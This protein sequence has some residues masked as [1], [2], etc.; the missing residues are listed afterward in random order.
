MRV[1]AKRT[2][3]LSLL[4][5]LCVVTAGSATEFSAAVETLDIRESTESVEFTITTTEPVRYTYFELDGP[6]L[7]VDFHDA[8]NLLGSLNQPVGAAGVESVRAAAFSNDTRDVT[9]IV[10]D[11]VEQTPYEVVDDGAGQVR[12]LFGRVEETV[13]ETVAEDAG[14]ETVEDVGPDTGIDQNQPDRAGES[15]SFATAG[16]ISALVETTFDRIVE[17]ATT[18]VEAAPTIGEAAPTIGEELPTVEESFE[19]ETEIEGVADLSSTIVPPQV[20]EPRAEVVA[21]IASTAPTQLPPAALAEPAVSAAGFAQIETSV[22]SVLAETLTVQVQAPLA[23]APAAA[24]PVF[25]RQ[26]GEPSE[27]QYTGEIVSFNLVGSELT[28]FFR[29]IAELSG[30]NIILDEGVTGSLTLVLTEVPWDQALD[31]VLRTNNLGYELEG[32]ILRIAPQAVFQAEADALQA[33]RDA[34][35]LNVPMETR[36]YILS[37]TTAGAVLPLIT[38]LISDAAADPIVDSRRNA[39]IITDIPGRFEAIESLI[40]FLDTPS[41]QVEIEARLLSATKSFSRELG[42]LL[43]LQARNALNPAGNSVTFNSIL[44]GAASGTLQFILGNGG[45]VILDSIITTAEAN[46]TAKLLSRPRIVTQNNVAATVSQG[47]QIPVQTNVNNTISVDFV[48]F[49][50]S[51]EV[52]PQITEAGTI[53]LVATI[54]NSSPDFS[55]PVGGIPAVSTQTAQTTVLIPDGGTAV[56]GGILIDSDS[57]STSQIPGLGSIPVIGS[58]FR[59][60]RTVRNTSELLFFITARIKATDPLEFLSGAVEDESELFGALEDSTLQ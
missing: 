1:L 60:T 47:T 32:N 27:P 42:T 45:D 57:V 29:V 59:N 53:L 30:L 8:E 40:D 17:A 43:G 58:L 14:S 50:L 13:A 2:W 52:L 46:G 31:L 16:E 26:E 49:N 12:V 55:T 56:I 28:D 25:L 38:P 7:V 19:S 37:Y 34:Q 22:E 23:P 18:V 48:A 24:P 15:A 36:P 10:F 41:R 6:R 39:I 5:I 20:S 11:L 54:E 21:L 33:L 3:V 51:L 9:R 44:G 4:L 35:A